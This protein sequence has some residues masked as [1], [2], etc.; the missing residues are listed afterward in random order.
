[1]TPNVGDKTIDQIID[2]WHIEKS[3]ANVGA[4]WSG[5]SPIIDN[6]AQSSP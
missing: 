1:M 3:N 5:L 2:V 4:R 6:N